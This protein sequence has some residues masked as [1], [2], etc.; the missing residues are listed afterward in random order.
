MFSK[1]II[2]TSAAIILV[3]LLAVIFFGGN[4]PHY[5]QNP[6]TALEEIISGNNVMN[7]E[8]A[9]AKMND[10]G[11]SKLIFV[12]I[13][14]PFEY[15]KG[16]LPQAVNVPAAELLTKENIEWLEKLKKARATV[17]VFGNTQSEANAPT[18]VLRQTGYDNVY[19]LSGGISQ[20][21]AVM[22][23]DTSIKVPKHA[24]VA[25]YPY[26]ELIKKLSEAPAIEEKPAPKPKVVERV[27]PAPVQRERVV[28]GGC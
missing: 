24:E 19:M 20:L 13:R 6:A 2:I 27:I 17:I 15:V 11:E 18:L 10:N 7:I 14:S 9:I 4:E 8:D 25:G 28:E 3:L 22:N 16:S 21:L 1:K 12:D 23:A 26:A 5:A